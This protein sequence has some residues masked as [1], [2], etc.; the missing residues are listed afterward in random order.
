MWRSLPRSPR[1]DLEQ[2]PPR[3]WASA[4]PKGASRGGGCS[5]AG[6]KTCTR[7]PPPY[8]LL[9]TQMS[10]PLN[11]QQGLKAAAPPPPEQA[12]LRECT[13]PPT[14]FECQARSPRD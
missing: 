8:A 13:P 6:A 10:P 2:P 5:V 3:T 9:Q 7:P 12:G 14:P 4:G 11:L 1:M